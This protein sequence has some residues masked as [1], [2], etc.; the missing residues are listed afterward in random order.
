[1]GKNGIL[2][3]R[4]YETYHI[5]LIHSVSGNYSW[6]AGKQKVGKGKISTHSFQFIQRFPNQLTP[7]Q[8]TNLPAQK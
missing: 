8:L 7:N 1:M 5:K 2:F 6:T 3:L 4:I